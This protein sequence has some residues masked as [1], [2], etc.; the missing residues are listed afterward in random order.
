[1][2]RKADW[3]FDFISPF[4][5][6]QFKHL[7]RLPDNIDIHMQPVLLAGLLQHWGQKGPAEIPAK[8][9]QTYQHCQW[10]AKRLGLPFR[11]PPAH[12]FNPLSALRLSM[13]LG[14]SREVIGTIFD[15]IW[16]DGGDTQSEGGFAKLCRKLGVDNPAALIGDPAVKNALRQ[17]TQAAIQRGVYGVPTFAIGTQLFWGF[18]LTD[19]L[20]DYLAH[21]DLLKTPE[22][23][24]L[25]DL[26]SAASRRT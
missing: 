11:A 21:P 18:D 2:S 22:M 5:Y 25:A 10:L 15:H 9:I 3:Y 4:A 1:M 8:R 23:Q 12:P 26:P 19:M 20:L 7:H 6:F 17:G 24:R 13:A 16:R 14:N